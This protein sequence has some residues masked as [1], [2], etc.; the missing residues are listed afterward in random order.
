L[1]GQKPQDPTKN[2]LNDAA[3][4]EGNG[5]MDVDMDALD[6]AEKPLAES[7]LLM[8]EPGWS[9]AKAREKYIEIAMEDWG[10]P[11]FYLGK[12]GVLAA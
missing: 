2:G 7:P 1:T 3:N 12:T 8:T 6:D 9:S 10:T 4:G 11:A 5:V